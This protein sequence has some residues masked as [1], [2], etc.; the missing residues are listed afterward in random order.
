MIQGRLPFAEDDILMIF[1]DTATTSWKAHD[2][3]VSVRV[4]DD[5]DTAKVYFKVAG[6]DE[7]QLG[8]EDE[9]EESQIDPNVTLVCLLMS[10]A[11]FPP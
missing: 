3:E 4:R 10:V 2:S 9:E 8:T 7:S 1:T 6:P 5:N 11:K